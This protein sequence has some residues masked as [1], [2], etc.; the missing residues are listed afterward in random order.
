MVSFGE[1]LSAEEAEA[2]RAYVIAGALNDMKER[3]V[4]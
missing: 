1:Y 2:I 3:S 4:D